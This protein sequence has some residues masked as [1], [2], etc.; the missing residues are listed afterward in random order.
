MEEVVPD[1]NHKLQHLVTFFFC[2]LTFFLGGGGGFD[3]IFEKSIPQ[4][5]GELDIQR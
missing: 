3:L 2:I 1:S 4:K 5:M